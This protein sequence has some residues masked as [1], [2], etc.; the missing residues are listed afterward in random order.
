MKD[1]YAID[2]YERECRKLYAVLEE[3]LQ[4]RPFLAAVYSIADIAVL[5][6]VYRHARHGIDLV[7][8]P[9]VLN[10]YTDLM[11]RPAVM[12]GFSVGQALIPE[13]KFSGSLA[14]QSLF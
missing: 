1:D 10:W 5:P 14:K 7:Y 13:G 6:W 2:R 9:A 8:Y 12:K 3:Q 11:N 4:Q